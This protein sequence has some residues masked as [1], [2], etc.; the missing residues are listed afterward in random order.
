MRKN[1]LLN[2]GWEFAKTPLGTEYSDELAWKAVDIPHD[3]LIYDTKA[4]YEDS[5]GWYRRIIDVPA[6]GMRTYVRFEGVYMDCRVYVNGI[7]AGEW[8]YG[9]TTFEFDITDLLTGENDLLTV[10]VDHKSPNSRWYSGAGI[11]RKVWLRRT[12]QT[13]IMSDGVYLSA[14]T[15]GT[16]TVTCEV[17]R[18]ETRSVEGLSIKTVISRQK[19]I[20]SCQSNCVAADSSVLPDF[21][22]R[23]GCKYSVNTQTLKV[24]LPVLW[25]INAPELYQYA[26]YLYDGETLIDVASGNFG[27]R[28]ME[29]TAD[30]GFLLN[31]RQVK[32]H[33]CCEHHDLGALG[34]AV[35]RS[36][37]RR[38]FTKLREMGINAIRTSHN[39]PAVEFMELADEMGML[40]LSEGFD[41]WEMAKTE[42]DYA[43]FV[44]DWREKDIAS[45]IRRDRNHPSLIG[46]SIGNEI[47]DT[48]AGERGQEITSL[49]YKLVKTHDP[50]ENAVVTIGSNFMASENAQKCSDILKVAGYNYSERLYDEH[51]ERYPDWAIY[52]SETSSVVQSRGIYHFP[53]EEPI[54]N[55]DDEQCSSLGNSAP[56]WAAKSW[57]ACIIPDRDREFCAGQFIWTGFDYIGEPTPYSTK[58]SYFGQIDTAGFYK[59]SFYVFRA[60]WT[61]HRTAPFVHIFPYWDFTEGEIIDVRVASNAPKV[62]LYLNGELIKEQ[63]FDRKHGSD[64]TLNAKLPYKKGELT[65][66]AYDESG[67]EIA[68]ESKSSFNNAVRLEVRADRDTIF[69]KSDELIFLEI[70]ALD[71]E[72]REVENANNRVNVEVTGAGRLIGLDNGDSTDYEQYKGVSRRLFSGKLLAIIAANADE[73]EIKVKL[74]S[75]GLEDLNLSYKSVSPEIRENSYPE[76]SF[77]LSGAEKNTPSESGGISLKTDIPVRKIE[78]LSDR[79]NFDP[80]CKEIHFTAKCLPENNSYSDTIEYRI[81]TVNGID[82]NLAVIKERSEDGVTLEC[83]G[84]GEFYLRALCKN[85]TDKYHIL[86]SVRLTAQGLGSAMSDPYEMIMGG[87][88]TLSGGSVTN[89]LNHGAAIGQG[90]GWFGFENVDFGMVGSDEIILPLFANYSTPVRIKVYDGTPESGEL[91]GEFEYF[92]EPIWL[93][94]QA[95][96]YKL[97]KV[98]RG[99]H[100]ISIE[101]EQAYD[102]EG[103]RF[104]KR[105]KENS[106]IC[107]AAALNIYGDRFTVGESDVTDI[108]NN[109][110]LDFGEFDFTQSPKKLIITAR[111]KLPFNSIHV[112]FTNADGEKRMLAEFAGADEYTAREFATDEITGKVNVQLAF[113]PG[114]DIDLRS[115][116]FD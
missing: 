86:S 12:E 55:E 62:G 75:P 111:S 102:V 41:M 73:G 27:F 66:I 84:D 46:W 34:A 92:V 51:H 52:G 48:H 63:Q 16:V 2:K 69:A 31:G 68:R 56:G 95:K 22:T 104:V 25:D 116:K 9:Y 15:D 89:G 78:F 47:Y 33:G 26:V 83:R 43:R 98:L 44:K 1:I 29:F 115:I 7:L 32:L 11:Y 74:S 17:E 108:G 107:A 21:L 54:L 40:I 38:K 110:M 5:T 82:S 18:P 61:D 58:N 50:R 36:A 90:G 6:D 4:L 76:S 39:P 8:K 81:T 93:T 113:L 64:I 88:Y 30:R 45:W 100:T 99:V 10:R 112:I 13:H 35:N 71:N 67:K 106:E 37:I 20:V 19:P 49:L 70:F 60:A 3:W 59:D 23:E 14:K 103:F 109:V 77:D 72:G 79:R 105:A 57:E 101:S 94:Y 53:L 91:L 80:D 87:L 85:G 24:D 96:T 114:S 42:Y 65:A 28:R 97:P